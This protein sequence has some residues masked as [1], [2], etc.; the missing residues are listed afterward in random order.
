MKGV[1]WR[2]SSKK[3]KQNK[4]DSQCRQRRY[5]PKANGPSVQ[6]QSVPRNSALKLTSGAQAASSMSA[7]RPG[8]LLRVVLDTNVYYSA[9]HS[10]RGVPFELW[11][12]AVQR[13]YALIVS[14][15]IIA[16]LADVLRRDLKWP[17]ADIVAQ[18]KL[19]VRCRAKDQGPGHPC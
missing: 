13:K 3:R 12:R 9:Y 7:A 5:S 8:H 6:V 1:G 16:E 14:P 18:L 2:I 4:P 17:E 15:A 10:S 19:V 11:R